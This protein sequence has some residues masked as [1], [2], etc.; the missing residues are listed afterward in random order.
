LTLDRTVLQT[1][2][3]NDAPNIPEAAAAQPGD[4]GMLTT[5]ALQPTFPPEALINDILMGRSIFMRVFPQYFT[6]G[7]GGH[8][9]MQEELSESEFVEC[10]LYHHTVQFT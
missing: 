1:L 7:Q 9:Q 10:C 8:E 4:P 3:E 5:D 2:F 6:N